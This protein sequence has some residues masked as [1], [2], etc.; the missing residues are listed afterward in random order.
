MDWWPDTTS[1]DPAYKL[2]GPEFKSAYHIH[3]NNSPQKTHFMIHLYKI[4]ENEN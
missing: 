3:P 2:L 1:K 4:L